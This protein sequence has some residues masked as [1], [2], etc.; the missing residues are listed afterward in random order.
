M[1]LDGSSDPGSAYLTVFGIGDFCGALGLD[2]TIKDSFAVKVD[3]KEIGGDDYTVDEETGAVTLTEDY[4]KTP[5]PGDHT[6]TVIISG[7]ETTTNF[8]VQAAG[9]QRSVPPQT[10]DNSYTELWIVLMTVSAVGT[11]SL[12][13]F[14]KK[15]RVSEK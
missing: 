10:G 1:V 11:I 12:V 7:T 13:L 2:Y 3:G 5:A 9:E 6:L 14:D 4:L 15:Q 8:T